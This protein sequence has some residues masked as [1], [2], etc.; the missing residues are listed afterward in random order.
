MGDLG[1]VAIGIWEVS[2]GTLL[3]GAFCETTYDL[4]RSRVEPVK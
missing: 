3:V 1:G 2:M 4:R